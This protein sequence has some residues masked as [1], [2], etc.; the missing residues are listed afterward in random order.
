MR[1]ICSATL[2]VLFALLPARAFAATYYVAQNGND[3]GAGSMSAPWATL[4]HAADSVQAGDQVLVLPGAYAGFYLDRSGA[5]GSE[6]TFK[7]Q[8]G[9]TITSE[10]AETPDGINLEGASYVTIE[11]FTVNGME[12]AGLRAVLGDHVTL[13]NN[14]AGANGRWGILTGFVEDLLI[15]GNRTSGSL[16]EHGIYVSNSADRPIIRHNI[17]W[18]NARNGIHI[19]GDAEQG[20]DGIISGAVVEAN[21]IYSNGADGGSGINCDGVQDSLLVN[22]LI[23][24]ARASGIS[25]YRIDGGGPS[26][27][28][29]VINNTVVVA[30]TGRWALNIQD[31]S[32]DNKVFNNIFFNSHPARGAINLCGPGCEAGFESDYNVVLDRFTANDDSLLTLAAWRGATGQD[33]HSITCEQSAV[34]VDAA[35]NDYRVT[36]ASAARDVGTSVNAPLSDLAGNTRPAGGAVDIG[37]FEY[38]GI[39]CSPASGGSN[40]SG[41]SSAAG[42]SSGGASNGTAGGGNGTAGGGN[43]A[44]GGRA[45]SGGLGA[46]RGG[47]SA[48]GT[49][50]GIGAMHGGAAGSGSDN[51]S[52]GTVED[53]GGCSCRQ[54]GA[55]SS[56]STWGWL[57]ILGLVARRRR[58]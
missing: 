40:G 38:C 18:N 6:I 28:N 2:A 17:V 13:R 31:E 41:G 16:V 45:G 26:S 33:S 29:L 46:D 27:G 12:R 48:G 20:G 58:Q 23:Y 56:S 3:S 36:E 10:N 30:S 51:P 19:N 24:D 49:G 5:P 15:E 7:A 47:A 43:V 8:P 34:F 53:A 9:V 4:Q 54:V 25:L 32:S 39:N 42:S 1:R 35:A 55:R 14:Q 44:G 21:T 11:G 57:A 50:I 37:A 52:G 22:N